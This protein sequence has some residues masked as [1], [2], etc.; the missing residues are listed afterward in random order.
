MKVK[1]I[2]TR[3]KA[4]LDVVAM[5]EGEDQLVVTAYANGACYPVAITTAADVFTSASTEKIYRMTFNSTG[6]IAIAYLGPATVTA[7]NA[8]ICLLS[9]HTRVVRVPASTVVQGLA[10]T[11]GTLFVE[12]IT[13]QYNLATA[14]LQAPDA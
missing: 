10:T 13:N 7:T 12:D 8:K 1:S 11:A 9:G 6:A 3:N 5:P 4:L 14:S 2:R